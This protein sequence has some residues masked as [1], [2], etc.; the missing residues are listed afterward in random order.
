MIVLDDF[1]WADEWTFK[2]IAHWQ[3]V[4]RNSTAG[5]PRVL[6]LAAIRSEE[7]PAG[8]SIGKIHPT[9]ELRLARF[10]ANEVR[11]LLESM[12]GP[13]PSEAIELVSQLSDGSPFMASAVLRGMVES[14][15]LLAQPNGWRIES[16]ALADL[17]SSSQAAGLLSRRIDL[18][19]ND[20]VSLLTVG[21]VIGKEF[22]LAVAARLAGLPSSESS[23]ML[24]QARHRHIVWIRPDDGAAVFVHNEIREAFLN[25]LT[26]DQRCKLHHCVAEDLR[27]TA[28]NR[29]FDL[30]Y[31]FNAAGDVDLALPYAVAAAEQARSRH[32][33]DVAEQ[34]YRIALRGEAS[35]QRSSQYRIRE[36]LGDVL[37]LC[38][39][40]QE[41]EE[42]FTAA[43]QLVEGDFAKAQ[44]Q[45]KLGEL[46][47]KR[48][49]MASAIRAYE[50]ALRLLGRRIPHNTVVCFLLF[51]KELW[52]QAIHTFFPRLFVGRRKLQPTESVSLSLQLLSR[53]SYSYWFNRGLLI[54]F[55]VH[56][57]AMNLAER[58]GPTSE[59]A[60]I[61]SEHAVA[62][63]LLAA[64]RRGLAYGEKSL[65][66]R[67]TLGDVWG[68]GQSLSFCGVVCY[69]A[70]RF[71]DAIE[72]CREGVRLLERTGDYWEVH[73]AR[74]Q[75]AAS[76]YRLGDMRGAVE[77]AQ[78]IHQLG[79]DLGADQASGI[80]LDI[81]ALAS[82]G[83]VPE[84]ILEKEVRRKR[85]DAQG[86]AQ[87]LLAQGVQLL[88]A[89]EHERAA[90][91][92]DQAIRVS[93]DSGVM[94]IYVSPNLPWLATALRQ[95]A[96]ADTE[97]MSNRRALLLLRAERVARRAVVVAMRFHNDLPHALRELA[98]ARAMQG[99]IRWS[100]RLLD[101]SLRIAQR[102]RASYEVAQTRLALGQLGQELGWPGSWEHLHAADVLLRDIL[103]SSDSAGQRPHRHAPLTLSLADRFY[104]VLNAGRR[105]ASA[106]S[107]DAIYEEV[108]VAA[109]RLLR[110]EQ[111]VVLSVYSSESGL[112]FA[113]IG[114]ATNA[115]VNDV[116]V[117]RAIEAERAVAFG[118]ASSDRD[119]GDLNEGSVICVPLFVRGRVV[120]AL[121]ACHRHVR[122][123][124][125]QTEE[126]LAD[127]IATI[128]GAALEN[129]EGFVTLQQ[130]NETLEHR[131]AERT[132][133][134][135][136]RT[137]ELARSNRKLEQIANELRQAE[138]GLR[139]AKQA[140]EAANEAKSR[141]LATISHE[142][143]TPINGI[144]GM[145]ELALATT[146]TEQQRNHLSAIKQSTNALLS[147]LSDVLDFSKIEAGRMDLETIPFYVRDVIG[148]AFQVIAASAAPKGIALLSR[149]ADD[150][151]RELI[152]DPNRLRQVLLNL[153]GNAVKFTDR[154]DVTV[155]VSVNRFCKRQVSLRFEV[156]DTGIGIPADKQQLIF[157]AFR[158]SD[159]S[160]TRRFG[161]TGLGLAISS[162]LVA[163]MG[164]RI[165][166]ESEERRGSVFHFT[167]PFPLPSVVQQETSDAQTSR[168]A[169][170]LPLRPLRVLVVDDAPVNQEVAVGLLQLRGH[171]VEV[172]DNGRAAVE[173][174][175]RQAF[176]VV[177]M[178]VEMPEMD[179]LAATALIREHQR[180]A[181]EHTAIV[182]MT[183]HVI[184]G[185]RERCLAAGM[186][187]YI[188]KPIQPERLFHVLEAIAAGEGCLEEE[189]DAPCPIPHH[190]DNGFSAKPTTTSTRP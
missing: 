183:A 98:L 124:F 8:H 119:I 52:I 93:R 61:Y 165:G 89:G 94:N 54:T 75:I 91:T 70:S 161:G 19:P 142:I 188:S 159:N 48:G 143:R 175:R 96:M 127:F 120:A 57:H 45:G 145:T 88:A 116:A 152:G 130:L 3:R 182:A 71:R 62:L 157:E 114:D 83:R 187:G 102:Q 42:A 82:R 164:G 108:R 79:M 139:V 90:A 76:L 122:G 173:A 128:A 18:L 125:G 147:L 134:A 150:V 27:N 117:H 107:P 174:F 50:L 32:L 155:D 60:Q 170:Q 141:F 33:L 115:D 73:I 151:P 132:A 179:G 34:Q 68:Q 13:L 126:R 55:W 24:E 20:A 162:Q 104:T 5:G 97:A 81:W 189:L 44:I 35:A 87:V 6:V 171:E 47:F 156:R 105:I 163:L 53:L 11:G 59:L 140:A 63:T 37:M 166:V 51:L 146:L 110:S 74:Y 56:L 85:P 80:S 41:A 25:R 176:D 121:Y 38:G 2:L 29:V 99:K 135:E 186:D 4:Q 112:S 7:T 58:F 36:G 137:Q 109:Q 72:K 148:D 181:G 21:A 136:A 168:E 160:M 100:R 95:R 1:Q 177:L 49:D 28:P 123:L 66:I 169:G 30:A 78:R 84:D 12:A 106:L 92:F 40:Y 118:E 39:R 144:I 10:S 133:A 101:A 154:G 31:H 190:G 113:S 185:F 23:S 178:D 184:A 111:C 65:A 14:G 16:F 22:D 149:V 103:V 43:A 138:D 167:V 17:R 15:A 131:V 153:I 77:E 26:S 86:T 172:V 9:L 67:R 69:A 64:Y 46:D 129:A 180:D 158:Q